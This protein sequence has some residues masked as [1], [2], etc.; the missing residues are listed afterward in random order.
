MFSLSIKAQN[1]NY[2]PL[3]T[4]YNFTKT[5]DV[6][7]P[8]GT[9]E[10][11]HS[12]S[13]SGAVTYN[14]PI[15]TPLGTS[16]LEPTVALVYSSQAGD[17]IA[18][19]G[20]NISGLSAIT[21]AGKD[22]YHNGTNTPVT[23]TA[24]D[25][26]YLDG[27][28]LNPIVGSNGADATI[29]AT[30]AETFSS[31]ISN[32]TTSANNPNWFK[33]TS[34]DGSI[35]EFGNTTDSKFLYQMQSFSN[36]IMWRLNKIIDVNGNYIEF[37]YENINSN[38]RISQILYTGNANSGLLPYNIINFYY[39]YRDDKTT[40]Y[41]SG[42][43]INSDFLLDKITVQH[44]NDVG[45]AEIIKT[46]KLNYGFDNVHSI[47][48]EIVEFA[49]TETATSL[50][51]TILLYGEQPVNVTSDFTNQLAGAA[52]YVS[53][54]FDA[55][56]KTDLLKANRLPYSQQYGWLHYSYALYTNINAYSGSSY[57]YEKTLPQGSQVNVYDNKFFNFLASDYDGDGRDDILVSK[58]HVTHPTLFTKALDAIEIN[59][60]KSHNPN[61]SYTD[62]ST[63]NYPVP[64]NSSN[65]IETNDKYF[66]PGDFDG[67]GNQDYILITT[68]GAWQGFPNWADY[69]SAYFNSPS[70]GDVNIKI[71]NF[72]VG[73]NNSP[74]GYYDNYPI[75]IAKSDIINIIDF[76]GDG[77]KE[78]IVTKGSTTYILSLQKTNATT[79]TSTTIYTTTS[80]NGSCKYFVGDFNADGKSDL[81]VKYLNN[82]WKTFYS[83]GVSFA[84]V[85]FNFNQPV[86]LGVSETQDHKIVLADFNGDGATDILHAFRDASFNTKFSVY[87]SKAAVNTNAFFYEQYNYPHFL[88]NSDLVVGDFNGDG[89]ADFIN[90][91]NLNPNSPSSYFVTIKPF[92]QERLL[93]KI[94]TGHNV[95]TAFEYQ[96]LTD[97]TTYPWFYKRTISLDDPSNLNPYNN[98]Q[99]P[100]YAVS[101]ISTPT[102]INTIGQD[103]NVT[104][105]NYEDATLNR[106]GRG[107]LGFK[108][109]I[110]KNNIS[111]ITSITENE[112][113]TQFAIPFATRQTT[114]LN[115]TL[116]SETIAT[117]NF[118]NLSTGILD[119]RYLHTVSKSLNIDHLNGKASETLNTYDIYGNITINVSKIGT[120]AGNTVTPL[121]TTT[122]TTT[123]AMH[124][125]PVP[126]VPINITVSNTRIGM[127][128]ASA[129]TTFAYNALGLPISK[130]TFAGLPKAITTTYNYDNFGN[131]NLVTVSST[132]LSNKIV[133]TTYD[134][135]GRYA[136]EKEI[137]FGTSIAQ[138]ETF[139]IDSKWGTPL[140]TTTSDCLTSTAEY[141]N[142]G[143][144]IQTSLPDG[145]T[146]T[147]T[148]TWNIAANSLFTSTVHYAAGNPD[149]KTY[150]DKYGRQYKTEKASFA[151]TTGGAPNYHTVLTTYDIRGN[152]ATTTNTFFP[153]IETPRITTNTFDIYNRPISTTNYIG[154]A[155]VA[156]AN[157]S[158]GNFQVTT[159]SPSGQIVSKIV[160]AT[161][162]TVS[163]ID[164]GGQLTFTYDSRGNQISTRHDVTVMV[165][166]I[167]DTY[168][169]QISL[170]D[171]DAGTTTY[172]YNAYNE[173]LSQTDAKGNNYTFTYDD[174]GRT[175]TRTG[176][177]GTTT[178]EYYKD[179][180]TGCNNNNLQKVTGFNGIVKNYTYDALKRLQSVTETGVTG[181]V[182][183]RTTTYAYNANS[184]LAA[185]TYPNNVSV[186]NK[187]DANGYLIQIATR[188]FFNSA[189][190]LY[191]NPQINGQGRITSY[192]LGNGKVTTKTYN[193]DYPASTSTAGVQNLTY[194]FE[195]NSGNLLQR[196]DVL[197]SQVE[198]FTYD[199]LN[200]LKTSVVNSIS[201]AALTYDGSISTS[202]GNIATKTDAGYYT[203]LNTKKHAV[204]FVTNTPTPTQVPVTPTPNSVIQQ[205][206]QLVTYTPFLRPQQINEGGMY[207]GPMLEFEYGPDYERVQ[208]IVS[209]GRSPQERKYFAGDYEEHEQGS[210][211]NQ[212]I[213]YISAGDG[214]CA[215]I[216]KDN[217]VTTPYFTYTD[218]LGSIVAVTDKPGRIVATQNFDAWGR[219]RN[220]T[221]WNTYLPIGDN[222]GLPTWLYRGYTGHEMLPNFGLI[223]MNARL[224]D[225][226]MGR[227]LSPD[228]YINT[229]LGS[230][231][232]NRYTY[233]NNNPLKFTD[234]DGNYGISVV[235]SIIVGAVIGG[236]LKGVQYDMQ[237]KGTFLDGFWRGAVIGGVTGYAG[238][239]APIGFIPGMLYGAAVGGVMGGLSASLD[240]NNF[241]R[242][243]YRGAI[244]GGILGGVSGALKAD[245]LDANVL[246]GQRAL[247]YSLVS[248]VPE[249]ANGTAAEY[250]DEYLNKLYNTNYKGVKG[251]SKL[252]MLRMPKGTHHLP[253]GS[254]EL[255]GKNCLAIT[256]SGIWKGGASS[257]IMFSRAAFESQAKLAH[258]MAHELGHVT[259]DYIGLSSLANTRTGLGGINDN[260]G[261]VAIGLTTYK[262]DKLNGWYMSSTFQEHDIQF[263]ELQADWDLVKP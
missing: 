35:M 53:G 4:A 140:S 30:E 104:E 121:E 52:D 129:T 33:V 81:L 51:S 211:Y 95:T 219:Y 97:K 64:P 141:N 180:A 179:L 231:G 220:P 79:Y 201:Q 186:Y 114:S 228:N 188:P 42:A 167:F 187:Y 172:N 243:A 136:I 124:N 34:K 44:T 234:P 24:D 245:A 237:G 2:T 139:V 6:T 131:Q 176:G 37:K 130:I 69:Y 144:L 126:A 157:I 195:T 125:T 91:N 159:T 177:E 142:F 59:F 207:G 216:V 47:L 54:D 162:K 38:S 116:L 49:G 86:T 18:G 134:T 65:E 115:G 43:V 254:W 225:P 224:Y 93:Q 67:N 77:K 169:K 215:M 3:Y 236:F 208:T 27:T 32:T 261:H 117:N 182:T 76:D 82:T 105:F 143:K 10:G 213:I 15:Y 200:R 5:I 11:S 29:Y 8:V 26:F 152:V 7:K 232:L 183:S 46:Y 118:T 241:W 218:Y 212:S 168:G 170:T 109:V 87:Y 21:R 106:A 145:N 74:V 61:T 226:V 239:L 73:A 135:K 63:V 253:N 62:Y 165:S 78:I 112:I 174:L 84:E 166:S 175:L 249:M 20:W 60:T 250:S 1:T 119:K 257:R 39:N 94:T 120:L 48:K 137:G 240:G 252:T 55:D 221:N 102:G 258:I 206:E 98:V 72:G 194:N 110:S 251:V 12:A 146:I 246:T 68:G 83:T 158:N 222:G 204:A 85:P 210:L 164:A 75:T 248:D 198:N 31:I 58:T 199:N 50:N 22:R 217:G 103:Q 193:N 161:G 41:E 99:L 128:A 227:M 242:G 132:G 184:A 185:T 196:N 233:A 148:D 66:I 70:I 189:S 133:K 111:G 36:T 19:Y 108:K 244:V 149:I 13:G 160:D 123:F 173:L 238:T 197:N 247:H 260:E 202:M 191:Y 92:G 262:L 171:I 223:N 256:Q 263:L 100:M 16:S 23:Y 45:I 229:A 101:K 255:D 192:T 57:L 71:S 259:H 17:G 150:Y 113:N 163:T 178:Y 151:N 138:K 235:G 155:S 122:T 89:R 156:Y 90:T 153:N 181:N 154:T 205:Q 80:I 190:L 107:F 230:Q 9:V 56:G 14:I 214:L 88:S 209:L 28:R 147:Y 25:A 40:K 203:Y 96:L 127:P